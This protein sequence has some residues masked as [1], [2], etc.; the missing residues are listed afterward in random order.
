MRLLNTHTGR[1]KLFTTYPLPD[2]AILSHVWAKKEGEDPEQTFESVDAIQTQFPTSAS[3]LG[4]LSQKIQRACTVA[5]GAGYN[6]IWIDTCCIDKSSSSELSE[7]INS[8]YAWYSSA[9]VCFAYLADVHGDD[10][11]IIAR[12]RSS[13]WFKRVWT[14]QELIAPPT[15][16]FLSRSWNSIGSKASLAQTI[17]EVTNINVEVLQRSMPLSDVSVARRMSW[18]AER[19]AT[20]RE[21]NAYSL[22]G[23]FG[24]SLTLNYGEGDYAFTRF[25]E[26]IMT[27]I[28]DQTL[29]A[30]G[31]WPASVLSDDPKLSIS[32]TVSG[33]HESCL[34]AR[35]PK[36]FKDWFDIKVIPPGEH[37]SRRP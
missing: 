12:F 35:S 33:T 8:M 9:K 3:I 26:A 6:Y 30:W 7:A 21:D 13:E 18:A 4:H 5:D 34:L 15:V 23:I 22:L 25:Q 19:H 14:L 28:P 16:V 2:Y 31:P 24:V 36:D 32:R 10:N 29:F 11:S 17:H 37:S 1:L 27:R 20:K